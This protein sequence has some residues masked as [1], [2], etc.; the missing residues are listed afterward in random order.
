[1]D[2]SFTRGYKD[3][4]RK[5]ENIL[6]NNNNVNSQHFTVL[7]YIPGKEVILTSGTNS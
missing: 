7:D 6:S 3:C 4:K 1:M 5:Y 2:R